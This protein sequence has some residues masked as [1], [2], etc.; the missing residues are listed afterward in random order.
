MPEFVMELLPV[1]NLKALIEGRGYQVE[2]AY[3]DQNPDGR[4]YGANLTG[5]RGNK[6]F[7]ANDREGRFS[8]KEAILW[9]DSVDY[10]TR[11][12]LANQSERRR[13]ATKVSKS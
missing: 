3:L 12:T 4:M 8:R 11:K 7:L 9:C 13:T 10:A 2:I 6:H 5:P 1:A